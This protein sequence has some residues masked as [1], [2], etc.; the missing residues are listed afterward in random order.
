MSVA[1][2]RR[3]SRGPGPRPRRQARWNGGC[4]PPSRP[5]P[6]RRPWSRLGPP[7]TTNANARGAPCSCGGRTSRR[8]HPTACRTAGVVTPREAGQAHWLWACARPL[9]RVSSSWGMMRARACR[10]ATDPAVRSRP[11]PFSW[12]AWA[13]PT[14]PLPRPPGPSVCPP[15]AARTCGRVRPSGA[16][17]RSSC[18]ITSQRPC[19]VPTA[20]HPSAIVPLRPS[21]SMRAWWSSPRALP[22]RGRRPRWRSGGQS[23]SAGC[24]HGC[25]PTPASPA[26]R[27]LPPAPWPSPAC[28]PRQKTPWLPPESVCGAGPASPPAPASASLCLVQRFVSPYQVLVDSLGGISFR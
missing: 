27:S 10:W 2:R 5:E 19:P 16:A 7:A 1:P 4:G 9:A 6:P 22:R 23:W 25:G 15:G 20:L 8:P 28:P 3:V 14:L 18:P 11:R 17:P 24:G 13:P 12:R 26:R 21:P